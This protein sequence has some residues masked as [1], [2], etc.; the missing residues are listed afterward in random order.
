[1]KRRLI[2]IAPREI[3]KFEKYT[4]ILLTGPRAETVGLTCTYFNSVSCCTYIFILNVTFVSVG[5]GGK[6]L[7]VPISERILG[8]VAP[9]KWLN[10]LCSFRE[11]LC[12]IV[13]NSFPVYDITTRVGIFSRKTWKTLRPTPPRVVRVVQTER[14]L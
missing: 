7:E 14:I 13:T 3:I 2:F 11:V 1:M 10:W 12:A 5:D 6:L 4:L 8:R 9:G